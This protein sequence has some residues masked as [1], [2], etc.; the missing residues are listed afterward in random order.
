MVSLLA[1]P[2]KEFLEL[3]DKCRQ[4]WDSEGMFEVLKYTSSLELTC[5][6]NWIAATS[7]P[8]QSLESRQTRLQGKQ[9]E[10]LIV[11]VRKVLCWLAKDPLSAED[12]FKDAFSS[13]YIPG[14]NK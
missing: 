4:Y 1:P 9:K 5:S 13:Q 10:L 6:C 8:D 11:F 7:I 2:P 12:L 14:R 3:S